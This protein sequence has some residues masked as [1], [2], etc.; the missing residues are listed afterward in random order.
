MLLYS[1][2]T[3]R[4]GDIMLNNLLL[5]SSSRVALAAFLHDLGKFAERARIDTDARID[6]LK[7][8]Y[9]PFNHETSRHT[10]IHAAYTAL[11]FDL[12][13]RQLPDIIKGDMSPFDSTPVRDEEG[14]LQEASKNLDNIVNASA[15]HHLPN[16]FLQWVVATADRVASGFERDV[17]EAYNLAEDKTETGRNHYQARQLTLVEQVFNQEARSCAKLKYCYP[18]AP[19]S[20][21][22]IFPRLKTEIEPNE[23]NLAQAEY[24][25][26]WEA[27]K[28]ALDEIPISHR[29]SLPL[30]LDHFDSAWLA[31]THSIPAATS[32]QVRPDVSLYDHSKTTSALAVALWRYHHEN[33]S[34]NEESIAKLKERR[35]FEE[36]KFLMIQGDFFGIQDFVF[37]QGSQT[38]Q[39]AAK[40]LRGRSFQVSLF[41]E[42]A[43]LKVLETLSL[44]ATCQILNA[45]GKFLI[46]A[47]NTQQAIEALKTLRNELN[48]WFVEHTYGVAGIGL[49]WTSASCNDFLSHANKEE[50]DFASL[51]RRL[52][53]AQDRAKHQRMN[54]CSDTKTAPIVVNTTYP[55][56]T[57]AWNERLPADS[58]FDEN[59][60]SKLSHDQIK[61]GQCIT[62]K[63]RLLILNSIE[64]IH[65]SAGLLQLPVFGYHLLFSVSE[66][67]SGQ[68][69]QFVKNGQLRRCWDFSIPVSLNET[70]FKGYARRFI[71]GYVPKFDE[72]DSFDPKKYSPIGQE[73]TYE[74]MRSPKTFGHLACEDRRMLELDQWTGL[75][76]LTILKGDVDNLGMIFQQGLKGPKQSLSLAK[77]ASFS[78]QMNAFFAIYLPALCASDAKYKN[79]YTVFAGGDDFF[80]IGPWHTTQQFA[81]KMREDFA[82]Y[83]AHNSHI[84][85]SAGMSTAKSGVPINTIA[86]MSEEAL[87]SSKQYQQVN[88]SVKNAV[89]VFGQTLSWM[90]WDKVSQAQEEI[91][92]LSEQYQLSTGYVY[93]L[94]KLIDLSEKTQIIESSLW[95]SRFVYNTQRM[96]EMNKSIDKNQ[97]LRVLSEL[98]TSIAEK[99][100]AQLKGSYKIALFNYFYLKRG[101]EN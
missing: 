34:D 100:I 11:A 9:C 62:T 38:N 57:C 45:A 101:K 33:R 37:A 88:G 70:L 16:T 1:E 98:A 64:G 74:E 28:V 91:N 77:M 48:D 35:D 73:M 19:L 94:L 23:N 96:L 93:R 46:V 68:F 13:A 17:F 76:A 69:S 78:R 82:R 3:Q 14:K 95:R 61:I 84:H 92:R 53:E 7:S 18:L 29:S 25:K 20:A 10:H 31:F 66:E 49:A 90:D 50:S 67:V 24:Q 26:L 59:P 99:G 52:F 51:M 79:I 2:A 97:R 85:F 89:T 71:N 4:L 8:T 63:N 39:N 54:L 47:P 40:I 42:L 6:A 15:F 80:L 43:A 36:Q 30:W 72:N 58:K 81:G 22:A 5:L 60:C 32:F 44:P 87:D 55:N 86:M 75:A 65:N 27:F 83:V 41:S 12:I 56:G 21:D